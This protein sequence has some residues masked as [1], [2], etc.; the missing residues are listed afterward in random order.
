MK[1]SKTQNASGHTGTANGVAQC[2]LVKR[3]PMQHLKKCPVCKKHD[4]VIVMESKV[5]EGTNFERTFTQIRCKRCNVS[6]SFF[7]GADG[8]ICANDAWNRRVNVMC[9]STLQR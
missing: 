7:E 9:D 1:K 8:E 3:N 4:G 5:G 6:T 2:R